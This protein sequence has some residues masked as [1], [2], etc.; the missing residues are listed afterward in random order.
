MVGDIDPIRT[1]KESG[2]VKEGGTDMNESFLPTFK[3][4]PTKN[5]R[6][7]E[8]LYRDAHRTFTTGLPKGFTYVQR[9]RKR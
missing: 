1:R 6:D 9:G 5:G 4:S 7:I 3:G 2:D 8:Y